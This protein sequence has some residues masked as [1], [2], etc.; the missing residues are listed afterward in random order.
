MVGEQS[1]YPNYNP[2]LSFRLRD[3]EEK[4]RRNAQVDGQGNGHGKFWRDLPVHAHPFVIPT[5]PEPFTRQ[6]HDSAAQHDVGEN[7]VKGKGDDQQDVKQPPRSGGNVRVWD[8]SSWIHGF[9][10]PPLLICNFFA[11]C[12]EVENPNVSS[13]SA[14]SHQLKCL[15]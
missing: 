8:E 10:C 12:R 2:D 9:P 5:P 13:T 11:K 7:Q 6:G 3:L 1:N 15:L 4:Q 14:L